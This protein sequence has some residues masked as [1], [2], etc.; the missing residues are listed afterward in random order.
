L[1]TCNS[2]LAT[3]EYYNNPDLCKENLFHYSH[4]TFKYEFEKAEKTN[5]L[6]SFLKNKTFKFGLETLDEYDIRVWEEFRLEQI[7]FL[8]NFLNKFNNRSS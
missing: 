3:L 5:T 7:T 2:A 6:E 8:L 4:S 1:H